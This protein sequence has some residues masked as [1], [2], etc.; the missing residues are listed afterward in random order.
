M[1]CPHA[2]T[3]LIAALSRD[4]DPRRALDR[5]A[6]STLVLT[7]SRHALIA[8]LNDEI[9]D[10]EVRAVAGDDVGR[11][12]VRFPL[13]VGKNDSVV[14]YVAATGSAVVSGNIRDERE[15]G[16]RFADTISEYAVPIRD[17][18]GRIRAV[19]NVE[20][21]RE[22]AYDSETQGLVRALGDLAA[23]V[24]E[25]EAHVRREEALMRVGEALG[26]AITEEAMIEQVIQV[27]EEV[28]RLQACSIFLID[29]AGSRFVLRG[30]SGLLRELVDQVSYERS[31]GFTGWVCDTGQSILLD[32]PHDDP[33][34]RGKYVEFPSEQVASFLAAPIVSRGRSI[35]AIRALRRKSDNPFFDNRF[36]QDDLRLLQAIAEQ[37]AIGLESVRNT[38]RMI[39]GERMIAWGE[40]SAKSSHMIG[41][42]VFAL[43]GDLNELRHV[44]GESEPS[45]EDLRE[46]GKS[47]ETNVRRIEEI[48]QDFRDF[49]TATQLSR[50]PTDL[51]AL[52]RE[53]V[54]EVFPRRTEVA[55]SVDLDPQ[56]P[57]FGVDGKRLRR[58]VSELLEN[59]LS[60]MSEGVLRVRTEVAG[61]EGDE[62]TQGS[63]IAR[64]ARISIEDS[65]PG[66]AP[67]KKSQIFQPFYTGRVRGMGL[68]LSIVKGIVDAHGGYVYEGGEVGKGARF[69]ILLPIAD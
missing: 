20:S 47:L 38:E 50:E 26:S 48:L 11:P 51:N 31:E 54:E 30:T 4:P 56:M 61:P 55:L 9:G 68:G 36:R 67:E 19:L 10:L 69:V 34:W 35:G 39:R 1:G 53:T 42:R 37:L 33:R 28:L 2:L 14:G 32:D 7:G 45:A 15:H 17:Q 21:D 64:Y 24:L 29:N 44:L 49:V 18:N 12:S 5:L 3:D 8:V 63:K 57:T 13:D 40:L 59:S 60:H 27:A 22:E 41:N 16:V 52:V 58:A 6:E 43:K 25:R 46:L 62:R 23:M 66:V 65:G